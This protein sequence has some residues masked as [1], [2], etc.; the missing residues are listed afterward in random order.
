[1]TLCM[2]YLGLWYHG[3]LH[4][5]FSQLLVWDPGETSTEA[6]GYME[7]FPIP[8]I[9]KVVKGIGTSMCQMLEGEAKLEIFREM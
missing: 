6:G 4:L 5:P 9:S 3:T 8:E 7:V 2:W 1:M